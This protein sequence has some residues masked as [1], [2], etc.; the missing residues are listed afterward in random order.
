MRRANL[1]PVYAPYAVPLVDDLARESRNSTFLLQQTAATDLNALWNEYLT[2]R[3]SEFDPNNPDV[4]DFVQFVLS[5]RGQR[6]LQAAGFEVGDHTMTHADLTTLSPAGARADRAPQPGAASAGAALPPANLLRGP[7]GTRRD[8]APSLRPSDL[9]GVLRKV[10]S[11]A[12]APNRTP[13]RLEG[14]RERVGGG[15]RAASASVCGLESRLQAAR[16]SN[17]RAAPFLPAR[18]SRRPTG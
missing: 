15:T 2:R 14:P 5:E 1:L 13:Q 8:A 18:C 7:S 16:R 12:A 17:T 9:C 3:A 6:I 11:G 4:S 10:S